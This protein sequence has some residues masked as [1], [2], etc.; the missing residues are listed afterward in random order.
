MATPFRIPLGARLLLLLALAG[1]AVMLFDPK[2]IGGGAP[3]R[4][5]TGLLGLIGVGWILFAALR[6]R[7]QG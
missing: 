6:A 1:F 7:R 4:L 5:G 2:G 3:L